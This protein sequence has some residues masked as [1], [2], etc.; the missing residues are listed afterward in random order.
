MLVVISDLHFV[1]GTAGEHNLPSGAF[2]SVFLSDISSLAKGKEA[3][4]IKLLLMGDIVDLIRSEQWFDEKLEDRPWGTNGLA[5]IEKPRPESTTEQR[6]LKILGQMPDNG[7]KDA[8][9]KNT[10][11]Y[12]N[13]DTFEFFR[14]FKETVQNE[15]QNRLPVEIIYI[16]GNH[17]RLCNLYPSVRDELTKMLGLTKNGYTIQGDLANN[18]WWYRY[19]FTDEA[20]GVYARHGHQY[21]FWNYGGGND[22]SHHAHLK[23]S[24][25]DLF[26]TEFAVKLPY[27]VASLQNKYPEITDE[28]SASLKDMDNVRPLSYVMEWFYY[29][30]KNEDRGNTRKALDDAFDQVV[31]E[32]LDI[33]F[34]QQWRSP[35]THIDEALRAISSRWLRWIPKALVDRLDTEDILP[36]IMGATGSTND[37]E[38]DPYIRAAYGENMWK[39]NKNIQFILYGHTHK[40][41]IQPLDGEGGREVL[42]IN[43]GT[44]R[45]RI[46]KTIGLDKSPDFVKLKQM[47]YLA[48]YRE[49]EDVNNKATGTVSFDMW[50]GNKMK[51]YV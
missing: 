17:D 29:R 2:K 48:F 24:I 4:E 35:K 32:L 19:D 8:V 18:K 1:D 43:T 31:K 23:A 37:P 27:K 44:W 50:T 28:L 14:K 10:I 9:E 51:Y 39:E 45:E 13:W 15:F 6:C 20:Y 11:L 42:Y 5:D 40:P 12:Q 33:E 36:L 7:S 21:D 16:P 25:G 38:K 34:V 41:L 46:F 30:I 26:A 22:H 47:T 49:D 3:K